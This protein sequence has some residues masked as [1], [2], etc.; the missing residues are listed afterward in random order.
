MSFKEGDIVRF[1]DHEIIDEKF[2]SVYGR[3]PFILVWGKGRW[4]SKSLDGKRHLT[5]WNSHWNHSESSL[6]LD[7]FLDAARKAVTD[8]A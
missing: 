1:K 2:T 8:E 7:T 6:I 3:G 4:E 5:P